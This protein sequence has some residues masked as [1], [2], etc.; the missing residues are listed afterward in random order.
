MESVDG[1][2][3]IQ[4]YDE[5]MQQLKGSVKILYKMYVCAELGRLLTNCLL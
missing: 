4:K 2:E 5:L 1:K 3:M